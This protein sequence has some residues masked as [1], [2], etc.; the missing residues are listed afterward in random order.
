MSLIQMRK[1]ANVRHGWS[2]CQGFEVWDNQEMRKS[3]TWLEIGVGKV[4]ADS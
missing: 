3:E 2:N 1:H 4:E